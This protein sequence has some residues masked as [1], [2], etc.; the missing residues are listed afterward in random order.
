MLL[1]DPPLPLAQSTEFKV[2]ETFSVSVSVNEDDVCYDS[3]SFSIEVYDFDAIVARMSYV[4]VVLTVPASSIMVDNASPDPLDTPY[5]SPL[6][7]LPSSSPECHT[8]PSI[9]FHDMP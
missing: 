7:S 3:A 4:D 5:A 1:P 9:D 2:G 6:C 8:M